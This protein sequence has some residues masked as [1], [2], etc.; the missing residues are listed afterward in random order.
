MIT[1]SIGTDS[2]PITFTL[3]RKIFNRKQRRYFIGE[4]WF[5]YD[6]GWFTAHNRRTVF[7]LRH[8]EPWTTLQFQR[9][10]S[11]RV[12]FHY[13]GATLK[14]NAQ[15]GLHSA[16]ATGRWRNILRL[17]LSIL[18]AACG[19]SVCCVVWTETVSC[20]CVVIII[21]SVA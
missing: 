5:W 2:R 19:V 14:K 18:H 20:G 10:L 8:K 16:C 1:M 15:C 12:S 9:P 4:T 17:Y 11:G 3:L 21:Q 6:Q 13:C 7:S